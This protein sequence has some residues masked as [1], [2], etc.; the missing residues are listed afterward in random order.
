MKNTEKHIHGSGTI[1][2]PDADVLTKIIGIISGMVAEELNAFLLSHNPG[3]FG[4]VM[5]Q[6]KWSNLPL[7]ESTI[8]VPIRL[9]IVDL[10]QPVKTPK[11]RRCGGTGT[12]SRRPSA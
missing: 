1:S 11:S 9:K 6:T 10:Y 8:T 5:V 2:K 12:R 4:N 3:G 7:T